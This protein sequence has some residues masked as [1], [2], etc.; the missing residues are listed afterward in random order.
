M[1][2]AVIM[3]RSQSP[4]SV[5]SKRRKIRR[6]LFASFWGMVLFTRNPFLRQV[7]EKE[8]TPLNTGNGQGFRVFCNLLQESATGFACLRPRWVLDP[9]FQGRRHDHAGLRGVLSH[10]G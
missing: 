6:L 7:W 1:F 3:G 8:D 2:L 10:Q 4:S 5:L 9:G